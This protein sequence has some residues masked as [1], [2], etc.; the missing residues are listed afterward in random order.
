MLDGQIGELG[1]DAED[2]PEHDVRQHLANNVGGHQNIILHR[3]GLYEDVCHWYLGWQVGLSSSYNMNIG[4]LF[5]FVVALGDETLGQVDSSS[6][7]EIQ[8][9][10]QPSRGDYVER[11]CS[12]ENKINLK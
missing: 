12:P 1:V 3:S 6:T 8:V 4:F 2:E 9:R 7:S 5:H 10:V 11:R